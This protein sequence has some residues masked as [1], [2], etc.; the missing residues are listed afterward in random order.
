MKR[1]VYTLC[2]ALF[3][4]L[5]ASTAAAQSVRDS[6]PATSQKDWDAAKELFD[7][8][9]YQG[10][11]VQFQKIYE[12]TKNPRVLFN[13]GVCWKNIERYVKAVQVWEKQLSFKDELPPGDV[14]AINQALA[15]VR[16]YI[17]ELT[18]EANE[19]GAEILIHDEVVGKTPL[20]GTVPIDV[21]KNPV[22]LRKPGFI[23]QEKVVQV[24]KGQPA[25]VTF[26]LQEEGNKTPVSVNIAGA[27]KATI[28][29]DGTEMGPAPF[30]GDIPAGRHTFEARAPG[31][32]T[33]RQ[34][35]EVVYGEPFSLTLSL[36]Q[37]RAEGKVKIVTGYEDAVI[38]IDGEVVG[39]GAWEGV[40][41]AGGHQ[42]VVRKDGYEDYVEDLA[43]SPDQE[44]TV[45]I[46]LE[47]ERDNAWIYWTITGVAVV[48][49][50]AVAGY[51]VFKPSET[52]EVTGTL[53]PGV[54]PTNTLF[55]W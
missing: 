29:I 10:A 18:V 12:D 4:S 49:G 47:P 9:S 14:K 32:E 5:L 13:I 23:P 26:E 15:A 20:L 37:A 45:R 6:L 27:S 55:S 17:S 30:S 33:A 43:L 46:K 16:P 19:A 35:S 22:R 52:S 25:K 38:E 40:L 41:S 1:L 7:N 53:D 39:S 21:G 8:G 51:F 48:A 36:A 50:G 54:V 42:L 28:F 44:R 24:I 31:M 2:V 11:I 3:V 34:T